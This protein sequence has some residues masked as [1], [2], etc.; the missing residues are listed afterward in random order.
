MPSA[1]GP[2]G[3]LA[4]GLLRRDCKSRKEAEQ[5]EPHRLSYRAAAG[6]NRF[7]K[8]FLA[9]T[10]CSNVIR[11][12]LGRLASGEN[13]SIDQMQ[14]AVED[15]MEGRLSD[16]EI[17]LLLTGLRMK[18]ET[19]SEI[20]GAAAALRKYMTPIRTRVD[21]L[22][23]TCGTGGDRSGTFNISTAAAIV[24]AAA[25]VP[26]AKH[27]NRSVTSR[28]GSADVLEALGVNIEAD[29]RCVE[30]CLDELGTPAACSFISR[31]TQ[32]P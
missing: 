32:A 17:A 4:I 9:P 31:L 16:G 18:G 14:R 23:D 15:I 19:I 13:L 8:V 30:T 20:A 22:L 27:G 12:T 2:S 25:G 3:A 6:Y 26:V 5:G 24:T 21:G 28:S 11:A 10:E 29:V 7:G 1:L